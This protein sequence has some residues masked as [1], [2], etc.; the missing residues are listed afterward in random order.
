MNKAYLLV[1]GIDTFPG[2]SAN[3]NGRGVTWIHVTTDYKAEKIEYFCGPID[4]AFGQKERAEK[5]S[6]TAQ[7]Y[8]PTAWQRI[9]VGHSNGAAVISSALMNEADAATKA[10]K[11]PDRYEEVHLVAGAVNED[12]D[13]NGFNKALITGQVGKIFVYC[14]GKDEPLRLAATWF[15]R[16]LGYGGLGHYGSQKV[17]PIIEDRVTVI[18]NGR[19]LNFGHSDCWHDDNFDATMK[20]IVH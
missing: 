5:F 4:R 14:G 7:F 11:T 10:G 13:A 2:V 19:W 12:F 17:N 6:R 20:E 9:G 18:K 1:N 16:F 8:S 15:G 3:W